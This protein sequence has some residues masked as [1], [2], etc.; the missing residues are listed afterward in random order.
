ME[1]NAENIV[2]FSKLQEQRKEREIY[3][4]WIEF[5]SQQPH[6]DLLQTLV[7]EHENDFPLRRSQHLLD[8]LQHRA[9]VRVLSDRAQSHFLKSLLNEIQS[10]SLN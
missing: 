4:R 5:Y 9:L 3:G 10:Q 7:S 6:E 1:K 2:S 8:Q